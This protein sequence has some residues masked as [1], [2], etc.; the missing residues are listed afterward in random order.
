MKRIGYFSGREIVR[1]CR[2][3]RSYST[4]V[5]LPFLSDAQ[6]SKCR[7]ST[8]CVIPGDI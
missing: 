4:F 1:Q 2:I 6:E 7:L 3:E 5:L 8:Y